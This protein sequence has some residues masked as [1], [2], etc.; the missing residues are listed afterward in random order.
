MLLT[1]FGIGFLLWQIRKEVSW[2]KT[3]Q[4]LDGK[5][6]YLVEVPVVPFLDDK[7][8]NLPTTTAKSKKLKRRKLRYYSEDTET[9]SDTDATPIAYASSGGNGKGKGSSSKSSQ[10][11]DTIRY[12]PDMDLSVTY[13]PY[14]RIPPVT[15]TTCTSVITSLELMYTGRNCNDGAEN[16]QNNDNGDK[17]LYSCNERVSTL[18]NTVKLAAYDE[19]GPFFDG[20]IS[21]GSTFTLWRG[22]LP[23]N[24]PISVEIYT[25][26][27]YAQDHTFNPNCD[28]FR[29]GC[30]S[31]FGGTHVVGWQGQRQGTVTCPQGDGTRS[32]DFTVEFSPG[33][34]VYEGYNPKADIE[35][36]EYAAISPTAEVTVL[37]PLVGLQVDPLTEP[38]YTVGGYTAKVSSTPTSS[39][40]TVLGLTVDWRRDICVEVLP[41]TI[42]GPSTDELIN[43]LCTDDI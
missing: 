27:A 29:F 7:V 25:G 31:G 13:G 15:D 30:F 34:D 24:K 36:A 11:D 19:D 43:G 17:P 14:V 37:D 16:C 12:C 35:Y 10:K 33:Q 38:S 42:P 2:S 41:F 26:D 6:N 1:A 8:D 3:L 39:K 5:R 22:G 9:T 4:H 32:L 21:R 40:F 23:L 18:P 28:L 20:F